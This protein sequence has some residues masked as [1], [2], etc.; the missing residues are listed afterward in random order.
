M[1]GSAFLTAQ[2][3]LAAAGLLP[4]AGAFPAFSTLG[5]DRPIRPARSRRL[6]RDV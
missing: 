2:C 6:R 1:M 5:S 3:V 4:A